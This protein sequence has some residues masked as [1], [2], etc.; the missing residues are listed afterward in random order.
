MKNIYKV[1]IYVL[2]LALFLAGCSSGGDSDGASGDSKDTLRLIAPSDLTTLDSSLAVEA[3]AFEVMNATQEGLYRLD[4]DDKAEPA[5]ATGDPKKSNDGKTWTFKLRKDAKWS[6]GD[7]ITAHDFVYSWRRVVDPKTASEYAYMFENIKNAKDITAGKK[8]PEELGVKAIDDHTLEVKLIKDVPWMQ[9]L[10]AFGSFNPQNEKFVK[11]QGNKYGTTVESTLSNGPFVLSQWK[12]EDKWT[13]KPNKEYWDKDKVKLGEVNYKVIKDLQTA[14]NLYETGK[15]DS[16]VI[17]SQ[18]VAKYKDREDFTTELVSTSRFIRLNQTKNKDLAN[19]NLR[20]ALAKSYDK[21]AYA[22]QLLKNGSLP[23]DTLMIKDF[24]ETPDGKDYKD[25]VKSSLNYDKK[26]AK[27]LYEKA[28]KELGKDKF[29]IEYLTYDAEESKKAGQFMKEQI[30]SNL[31]GVTINIK[32]QPFKQKLKLESNKDYDVAYGGWGP[33]YPDPTTYLDLFKKNSPHN[34]SGYSNPEYDKALEEAN[35]D[36]MLKDENAQK[37]MELLQKAEGMLLD[38]AA[39]APVY[40]DGVARLRQ[41]YV[42]NWQP[43]KFGGDYSLKEVEIAG[44]K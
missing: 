39:I 33:D 36:E 1:G 9:S 20:K 4:K 18:N 21:K 10:F 14:L 7:P 5:I 26:E 31:P 17:E 27:K 15:A 41:P 25:G 3:G 16:V 43:H 38:D 35:S 22:D 2:V 29:S 23:S 44:A 12:T 42:K 37:R 30:E 8:K 28:K 24:V 13:L 40:Q 34:Q 19:E 32:Q 6:N 11:K